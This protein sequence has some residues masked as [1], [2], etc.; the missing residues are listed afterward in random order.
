MHS[1]G[2]TK[3][4]WERIYIEAPEQEACIIFYNRFGH[5]PHRV[6]CTCCGDDYSINS[7]QLS[8]I[9]GY[10]RNCHFVTTGYVEEPAHIDHRRLLKKG[11]MEEYALRVK[12]DGRSAYIPLPDFIKNSKDALFIF[13]DDIKPEERIGD[14]PQQGYVWLD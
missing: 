6:S 9:T 10:E 2:G 3:E 5:S 11:N 7:G 12:E 13:A 14:V 8:Q 1:G 4:K